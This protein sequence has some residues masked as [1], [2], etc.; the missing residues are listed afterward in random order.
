MWLH[1]ISNQNKENIF[2][3]AI[4][5]FYYKQKINYIGIEI[6]ITLL[7]N[8]GYSSTEISSIIPLKSRPNVFGS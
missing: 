8:K 5:I 4:S 6:T 7:K 3:N 1:V 2:F